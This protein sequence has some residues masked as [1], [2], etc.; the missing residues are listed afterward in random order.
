MNRCLTARTFV[1]I[2][3]VGTSLGGCGGTAPPAAGFEAT[4]TKT[5]GCSDV[6]LAA[7]NADDS[8]AVIFRSSGQVA[9]AQSAGKTM[10]FPLTLPAAGVTVY[11]YQG[12]G[13]S[14]TTCTD[15]IIDGQTR[16]DTARSAHSG[17]ATLTV[18][19]SSGADQ[20][21]LVLQNLTFQEDSAPTTA[22]PLPQLQISNVHVGWFPG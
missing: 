13:V 5:S 11:L 18:T 4:L 2:G 21:T 1:L 8:L 12:K 14:A 7:S 16:V 6:L 15:Y 3:L 20:A 19:P 22:V 9:A 10:V 17:T